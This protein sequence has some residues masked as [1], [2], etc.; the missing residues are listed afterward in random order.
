MAYSSRRAPF[1][2]KAAVS[3]FDPISP[4]DELIF[5]ASLQPHRSLSPRGLRILM[6]F[7]AL[8]GLAVTIPFFLLGAWPI[9]GFMGLDVLAIWLAFRYNNAAAR[10]CEQIFLSRF[11]LLVRSIS[12]RGFIREARFNPRWTRLE[13]EDHPDFGL[14]SLALVQGRA[15]IEIGAC[16]GRA[17]RAEFAE[18]FGRALIDSKR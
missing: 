17:E 6:G 11:D 4:K 9:V 18:A 10:A 1:N 14:E 3:D 5:S 15:R 2:H 13:R 12:W 7:V 16:L 8:A